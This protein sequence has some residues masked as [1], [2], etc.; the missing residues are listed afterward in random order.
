MNTLTKGSK[1][2]F[3]SRSFLGWLIINIIHNVSRSITD[4]S[5]KAL[6]RIEYI[7]KNQTLLRFDLAF[8]YLSLLFKFELLF[9]F[10]RFLSPKINIY[11]LQFIKKLICQFNKLIFFLQNLLFL[12]TFISFLFHLFLIF[13]FW[14]LKF[15]LS[16]MS[17]FFSSF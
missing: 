1:S 15:F 8:S 16:I 5:H 14:F 6:S 9:I 3:W 17:F 13:Q 12:S 7:V 2:S 11:L 4:V 10:F